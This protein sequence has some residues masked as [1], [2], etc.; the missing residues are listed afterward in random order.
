MRNA[1]ALQRRDAGRHVPRV[2]VSEGCDFHLSKWTRCPVDMRSRVRRRRVVDR[3]CID[4]ARGRAIAGAI[5]V[6]TDVVVATGRAT[7]ARA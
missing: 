4:G 5:A 6:A 2:G 7:G 3:S 1:S